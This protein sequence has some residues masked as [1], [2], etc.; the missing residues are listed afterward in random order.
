VTHALCPP[1][2]PVVSWGC[3]A[4]T[5]HLWMVVWPRKFWLHLPEKYDMMVNPTKFLQI[6]STTI[7]AARG[8]EVIMANYFLVALTRMV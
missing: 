8:D 3:M 7:L 5:P 2:S 6:Y 1:S 4:L